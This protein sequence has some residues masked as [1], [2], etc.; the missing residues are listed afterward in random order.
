MVGDS[1]DY[2]LPSCN[3]TSISLAMLE[4]KAGNFSFSF[5]RDE[6]K[7]G[8][9]LSWSL[10]VCD[11]CN[12]RGGL[13]FMGYP[14]GSF[15]LS[16][17]NA[18]HTPF[19]SFYCFCYYWKHH[20]I[21]AA[22]LIGG[23]LMARMALGFITLLGF[24]SYRWK[25]F[26]KDDAVEKFLDAYKN[27]KP[28]RYSYSDIKKMTTDFKDK[29][30]EGGFGSVY[31]GELLNGHLVAVKMLKG[32]KG[33]GQDFINEVATIGRI[34][35]VN[36]VQLVG[37][38]SERTKRALIYDF[39]PNGSLDNSIFSEKEKH[40]PLGWDRMHAIALGVAHGIEYLHQG[41]DM[42]ILHFD[43]KPHNILLD[44]NFNPKIADFGLA[45][46][47]PRG[48]YTISVTDPRGTRGY[49]APEMYYKTIGGVS[50]KADVYSFGMLLLEMVGRRKNLNADV[51]R[52][53]QIYF[54]SWI[55]EQLE[56]GLNI[57]IEGA[58][59]NDNKKIAKK[60]IMVGL[61]C[62]QFNPIDR[63]T[64]S[65]VIEMFEGEVGDMQ[66][67]PKPFFTPEEM[68]TEDPPGERYR[69]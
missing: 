52:V 4:Q 29:V 23:S 18:C 54:P 55:Y 14:N 45:R 63:P 57:E 59:E 53:S 68:P 33:K 22:K 56:K 66:M 40:I 48:H 21:I 49:I 30:G 47:Y 58:C 24:W 69:R 15:W 51:E 37:F 44:E 31:K 36:V 46:F 5:I 25:K 2:L 35:H 20:F 43:I 60:L 64:M 67:P 39:M 3:M 27:L 13:C 11:Q 10:L 6:L 38:C 62:I 42:Q 9:E 19:L 34:H 50:Y 65:K 12:E 1:V 32:P 28:R 17:D 7:K 26:L 41:C 16:C 8:F 61:W